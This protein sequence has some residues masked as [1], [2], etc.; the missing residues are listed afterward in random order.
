MARDKDFRVRPGRI[1]SKG[2]VPGLEPF[3][4]RC[5][6]PPDVRAGAVAATPEREK[7]AVRAPAPRPSGE[8]IPVLA[9]AAC[10]TPIAASP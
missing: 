2:G 10:S 8:A 4:R 3:W 5:S 6:M 7:A 1:R 9:K